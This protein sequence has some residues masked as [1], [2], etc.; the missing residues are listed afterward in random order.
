MFLTGFTDEAASDLPGQILALKELGWS[1]LE[2]RNIGGV[3]ATQIS[4][5]DFAKAADTLDAAGISV[6]CFG[7]GIANWAK[8]LSDPPASS[9]AELRQAIPRMHRLGTQ[10]IRIMSFALENPLPID[11]YD[12]EREVIHRISELVK[13]AADNGI[14]CV[15]ENC[16]G[17]AGQSFEHSLRLLDAIDSP[18]FKLVFDTG[19]PVEQPDVRGSIPFKK[20]D[21]WQF[22]QKVKN[23]VAYIHIKDGRMIQ[24]KM[25]FMFPGEGSGSVVQILEDL[26]ARG[27]DNGISI[28]PHMAAVAHD[29][30]IQSEASV[31]YSNFIEYGR[32]LEKILDKINWKSTQNSP[33]GV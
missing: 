11:N 4:D 22:Y 17:W 1:H 26:H 25:H 12:A 2:L 9:Y 10:F 7:S 28:E 18:S 31:K 3:N 27:Y 6:N 29:P 15:H 21:A 8:K 19:N 24:D 23:H 14:I 33:S 30:S 20:Q 13:I 5:S 32:R 16:S